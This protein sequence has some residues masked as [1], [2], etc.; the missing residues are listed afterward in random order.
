MSNEVLIANL[1][2]VIQR[3]NAKGASWNW[4]GTEMAVCAIRRWRSYARRHP[5]AKHPTNEQRVSD[6]AKG[7]QAHFEPDIPYTHPAEWRALAEAL[8]VALQEY[9]A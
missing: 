2:H 8:T 4:S 5:K 7:L 1:I 6:L 9:A 3:L